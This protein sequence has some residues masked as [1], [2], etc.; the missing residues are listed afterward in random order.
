MTDTERL[1]RDLQIELQTARRIN[2]EINSEN[3]A[4][5]ME[6]DKLQRTIGG[7]KQTVE[8]IE[9]SAP[10]EEASRD[11]A[12][13]K[14]ATQAREISRLEEQKAGLERRLEDLGS[15]AQSSDEYA[16]KLTEAEQ[17]VSKL[18]EALDEKNAELL[19]DAT[20]FAAITQELTGFQTRN[21]LSNKKLLAAKAELEA[22]TL[23]VADLEGRLTTLK[24][25]AVR[26]E[27]EKTA[28]ETLLQQKEARLAGQTELA[29]QAEAEK[30]K[31]TEELEAARGRIDELELLVAAGGGERKAAR[32]DSASSPG[33]GVS[34]EERPYVIGDAINDPRETDERDPDKLAAAGY[35]RSGEEYDRIESLAIEYMYTGTWASPGTVKSE[36]D[37]T[38][39]RGNVE[40]QVG[41]GNAWW[42]KIGGERLVY[43]PQ[44]SLLDGIRRVPVV[45]Q[46]G[47]V[48]P[49]FM[50]DDD[51]NP[52]YIKL[53]K[54][55]STDPESGQK[56]YSGA[57][58]KVYRL[59]GFV[60]LSSSFLNTKAEAM[61][62]VRDVAKRAAGIENNDRER[63]N[64]VSNGIVRDASWTLA[65]VNAGAIGASAS[66][67]EAARDMLALRG[68][69]G[70]S[71]RSAPT[72]AMITRT[73]STAALD[74]ISEHIL[75]S[76]PEPL[77]SAGVI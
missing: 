3:A 5:S 75:D 10:A 64:A 26:L 15:V 24:D 14:I 52:V 6:I 43:L 70:R 76:G 33:Q 63:I 8:A 29:V 59:R 44:M 13:E 30:A 69:L 12:K 25:R 1:I 41:R 9:T 65:D 61:R 57:F 31:K 4:Q 36:G 77:D 39:T 50:K 46:G 20:K 16:R 35:A 53:V 67:L 17:Q 11:S 49:S 55:P 32:T 37:G 68:D 42:G 2:D 51:L 60:L 40:V 45:R 21:E 19:G 73:A 23:K 18:Q 38:A 54:S 28:A 72:V 56:D 66:L 22:R 62:I 7:L 47:A 27:G 74:F 34:S 71:W 48:L 58:G